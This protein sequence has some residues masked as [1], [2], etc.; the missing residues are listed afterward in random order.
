MVLIEHGILKSFIHNTATADYYGVEST[1]H[2]AR[3]AQS[4]LSVHHSNI[5]ISKR[6]K[7]KARGSK[8]TIY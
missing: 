2:A 6:K 5:V 3:T 7:H 8:R 1:G 4:P